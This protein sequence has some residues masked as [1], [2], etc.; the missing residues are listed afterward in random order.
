MA[1]RQGLVDRMNTTASGSMYT[2]DLY[3]NQYKLI[4]E[5]PYLKKDYY[6]KKLNRLVFGADGVT[7]RN[8]NDL[9]YDAIRNVTDD[10]AGYDVDY[11]GREF[12]DKLP[13]IIEK[14]YQKRQDEGGGF[15]DIVEKKRNALRSPEIN[16]QTGTYDI[17]ITDDVLLMAKEHPYLSKALQ[18]YQ[19]ETGIQD[20]KTALGQILGKYA[21]QVQEQ[22]TPGRRIPEPSDKVTKQQELQQAADTRY[23]LLRDAIWNG[24]ASALA[25]AG[26]ITED[27][28]VGYGNVLPG[29]TEPES[30]IITYRTKDENDLPIDE[31]IELPIRT[32]AEKERAEVEINKLIDESQRA[33]GQTIG[34][35]ALRNARQRFQSG[36]GGIYDASNRPTLPGTGN[37]YNRQ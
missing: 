3:T 18:Q 33:T 22:R 25:E 28:R 17:N 7:P 23:Q 2:K 29:E 26:D 6:K 10:A 19:Q 36:T 27:I 34:A 31:E 11:I 4:D 14:Y 5:N 1:E 16:T 32:R 8:L 15:Y 30:I 21:P 12:V 24:D 35:D 20:E 37:V 9:D 13:E